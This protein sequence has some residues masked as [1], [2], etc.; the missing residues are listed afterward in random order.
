M[1][2]F[3][4]SFVAAVSATVGLA[5]NYDLN[6]DGSVNSSDVANWII[7]LC[8]FSNASLEYEIILDFL[9]KSS[10]LYGEKNFAVPF[11]GKTWL[12]PAK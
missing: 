8:I 3:L 2:K 10:T 1:R 6:G 11:V 7:S 5:Q 12:G 4:F 9:I